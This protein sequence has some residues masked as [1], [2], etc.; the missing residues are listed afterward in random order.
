MENYKEVQARR[1]NVVFTVTCGLAVARVA[2]VSVS[3]PFDD[4]PTVVKLFSYVMMRRLKVVGGV[5]E[6]G[7]EAL[8]VESEC[9][10]RS[11]REREV[12]VNAMHVDE[13]KIGAKRWYQGRE[14][15]E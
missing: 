7:R 11:T 6:D 1:Q 8:R 9:C 3:Q 2:Q 13:R 12:G 15:M 4:L 10:A 5:A 14:K